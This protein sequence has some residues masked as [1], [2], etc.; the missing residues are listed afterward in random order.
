MYTDRH[1]PLIWLE[2]EQVALL[3]SKLDPPYVR[4]F[5]LPKG[6]DWLDVVWAMP[7][8][9][10]EPMGFE[11][12]NETLRSLGLIEQVLDEKQQMR[13]LAAAVHRVSCECLMRP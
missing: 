5:S 9:S 1:C 6:L 13:L 3:V 12:A 8:D 7:A 4:V 2:I 11:A 10:A